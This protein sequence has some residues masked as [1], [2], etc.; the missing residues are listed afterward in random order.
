MSLIVII[1]LTNDSGRKH[2]CR[3]R[4]L[5]FDYH[6][7][8]SIT[9]H[10]SKNFQYLIARSL[11]LWSVYDPEQQFVDHTK[12]APYGN[13]TP[14]WLLCNTAASYPATEPTVQLYKQYTEK[15]NCLVGRVVA[16]ATAVQ[17]VSGSI[18][19]SGKV[20]LGFFRIFL[21]FSVVVA[22][23]LEMCP[24]YGNRLTTYYMGLTTKI[25]KAEDTSRIN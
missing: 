8:Q 12:V 14:N 10:V 1:F 2:D 23:S 18:P 16:S 13:R 7:G 25:V 22:R 9:R 24:V 4:G 5:G 6:V 17:G 11:E 15:L 20:L 3:A 19:G 21:N